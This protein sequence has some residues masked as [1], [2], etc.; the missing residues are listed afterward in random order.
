M[1]RQHRLVRGDDMQAA[2]EGGFH[3]LESR[4]VGAADE[5]DEQVDFAAGGQL[6]RIGE[7][8]R[9]VE[10]EA[11]IP[12]RAGAHAGDDDVSP[13]ADAQIRRDAPQQRHQRGADYAEASDAD[14]QGF[15]VVR[16][17]FRP[18]SNRE[19]SGRREGPLE[20]CGRTFRF[21]PSAPRRSSS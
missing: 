6:N 12:V 9:A 21:S 14:S 8:G 15:G 7:E 5:F 18:F 16:H 3:R 11:A 19:P 1:R 2:P 10:P 13:G 20:V 4:A 17:R